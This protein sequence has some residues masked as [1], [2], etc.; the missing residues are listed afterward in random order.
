MP[1]PAFIRRN[2]LQS[3]IA[4]IGGLALALWLAF[5]VFA[6]QT[7]FIDKTANEAAPF[8]AGPGASGMEGDEISQEQAAGM[9]EA[10]AG[11]SMEE[12]TSDPAPTSV[13]VL[14]AGEFMDRSYS[15]SGIAKVV[16]DGSRRV[17]RIEDLN[18]SNGPQ[19]NVYLSAAPPDAPA[20]DFDEDFVDLGTLKGNIGDQNYEISS[21]VDLERYRTVVIWCVRFRTAFGTA[22]LT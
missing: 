14:L 22:G 21:E 5:G 15:T 7:L 12:T 18:T 8:A 11:K 10:M 20:G 1:L 4:A 6:V 2:P 3:S 16:T 19:L 17:L 9:N 13:E